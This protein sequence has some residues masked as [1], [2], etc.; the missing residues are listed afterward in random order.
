MKTWTYCLIAV[1]VL[2]AFVVPVAAQECSMQTIT[3]TYAFRYVGMSFMGGSPF[4]ANVPPNPAGGVLPLH[5]P[6]AYLAGTQLGIFTIN[7]D[8]SVVGDSWLAYGPF[9]QNL[10]GAAAITSIGVQ[11][12]PS[13]E[14]LGCVGTMQYANLA[15]PGSPDTIDKFIVL[16]NGD[17]MRAV[18]VSNGSPITASI[19]VGKR[20]TR[21]LDAAPRCG[22]QTLNGTYAAICPGPLYLGSQTLGASAM[23][24]LKLEAGDLKGVLYSRVEYQPS[25]I[26]VNGSFT[27]NAD[28]TGDG[29]LYA[30]GYLPAPTAKMVYKLLTFDEGKG[31]FLMPMEVE[32]PG[33]AKIPYFSPMSC[34]VDRATP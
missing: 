11:K 34:Q 17:E 30:P 2:F 28:C 10:S 25:E 12:T 3:G 8:G 15:F 5:A 6:G 23:L 13:G 29:Y 26:P 24:H 33:G 1:A 14:V 4:P 19:A 16:N 27:V 7:P 31:A 21:S 22:Q 20:I 9:R 32:L 18:H